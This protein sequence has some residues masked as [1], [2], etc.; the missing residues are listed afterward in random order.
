MT[1]PGSTAELSEHEY[2]G[3]PLHDIQ[4]QILDFARGATTSS[5]G[6]D[7]LVIRQARSLR[8]GSRG[9]DRLWKHD[10]GAGSN[11]FSNDLQQFDVED[12]RRL[13]GNERRSTTLAICQGVRNDELALRADFH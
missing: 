7:S 2:N 11:L 13:G 4:A 9:R 6:P 5:R 12:E 10:G 8:Y 1:S 3:P